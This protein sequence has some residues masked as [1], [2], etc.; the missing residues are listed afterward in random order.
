MFGCATERKYTFITLS[1]TRQ[2]RKQTAF[3]MRGLF[4]DSDEPSSSSF[5]ASLSSP[6]APA[7]FCCSLGAVSLDWSSACLFSASLLCASRFSARFFSLNLAL[8]ARRLARD[9]SIGS[10]TGPLRFLYKQ[11]QTSQWRIHQQKSGHTSRI[12][13]TKRNERFRTKNCEVNMLYLR[14]IHWI[15]PALRFL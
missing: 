15:E 5:T 8:V 10:G 1:N 14:S 9:S 2:Q 11:N 7:V 12:Q 4:L 6:S 3:R 13:V